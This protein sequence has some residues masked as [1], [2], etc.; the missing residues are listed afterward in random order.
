MT[1]L[2]SSAP[3]TPLPPPAAATATAAAPKSNNL[4][5][6][7][8]HSMTQLSDSM[9]SE[10]EDVQDLVLKH[11]NN[12]NVTD[13]DDI[14]QVSKEKEISETPIPPVQH[15]K[16][17]RREVPNVAHKDDARTASEGNSDITIDR[18]SP[19][20][21]GGQ[22]K[23]NSIPTST[24]SC[25]T[26]S[27]SASPS[28]DKS[29]GS[30]RTRTPSF[31]G[32]P[33]HPSFTPPGGMPPGFG[34][35]PLTAPGP[36][37]LKQ[38]ESLM[39]RN[40][41]DLMRSLAAKYNNTNP[42]EYFSSPHSSQ[43]RPPGIDAFKSRV[44]SHFLGL[45]PSTSITP[46]P[47]VTAKNQD[48]KNEVPSTPTSAVGLPGLHPHPSAAPS[49]MFPAMPGMLPGFPGFPLVDVSSTQVLM[50][51]V[52]NASA[53]ASQQ[54]QLDNYLRGA[55]KRP[56]EGPTTPLD[57][58]AS[59][60]N[61]RLCTEPAK[62]FDVKNFLAIP[63]DTEKRSEIPKPYTKTSSVTTKVTS[64]PRKKSP[65]L[66]SDKS[67]PSLEVIAHWTVE[68]VI[69]FVGSIDLCAEYSEAFRENRIDGSSLPLL[70]EE[71]LTSSMNMK[72]GPA[73]KLRSVLARKL[74]ACNVCLHC[75]HC[76][77]QPEER[78][79]TIE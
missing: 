38:M 19:S 72:L 23:Q 48:K 65:T 76:H 14:N 79:S 27:P 16:K 33:P 25:A 60:P 44:P 54:A 13:C 37:A 41:S 51:L 40:C 10:K 17:L 36:A 59:M 2:A 46:Y 77:V 24:A 57:L 75:N 26:P 73:I 62:S 63:Q 22:G 53:S 35:S 3:V 71:H 67:C 55:S 58:S 66:C 78:S 39:N 32:T 11:N 47:A 12:N 15:H 5:Q 29:P 31:P 61:K 34:M 28:S 42:N 56:S 49:P 4:L 64:V 69:S 7:N 21:G 50:N 30:H 43:V 18:I 20:P 74:G 70:T 6:T 68:D 1:N 8:N 52:R 45:P 9:T